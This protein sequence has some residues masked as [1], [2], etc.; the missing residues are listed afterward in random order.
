MKRFL[1]LM[2]LLAAVTLGSQAVD[3]AENHKTV[4]E[5]R[6][7]F[8]QNRH[9]RQQI[10]Q[11][12]FN[13]KKVTEKAFQKG[14][15]GFSTVSTAPT[16]TSTIPNYPILY[17]RAKREEKTIHSFARCANLLCERNFTK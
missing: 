15:R 4:I 8:P 11:R 2:M 9:L 6:T 7:L 13:S 16:I 17:I 3:I 5:Y 12:K 10:T 14:D 1:T